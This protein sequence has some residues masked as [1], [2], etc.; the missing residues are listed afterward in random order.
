MLLILN[1]RICTDQRVNIVSVV[2]VDVSINDHNVNPEVAVS[3]VAKTAKDFIAT[4]HNTGI[5]YG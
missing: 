1:E 3:D 5:R 4:Y 2:K